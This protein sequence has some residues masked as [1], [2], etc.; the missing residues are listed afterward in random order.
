MDL[1]ST[2]LRISSHRTSFQLMMLVVM[3]NV[4]HKCGCLPFSRESLHTRQLKERT[5][6]EQEGDERRGEGQN[7]RVQ[8]WDIFIHP[9]VPED[10]LFSFII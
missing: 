10:I 7:Q 9:G 8:S 1:L 2:C 6:A 5:S 4:T 3:M